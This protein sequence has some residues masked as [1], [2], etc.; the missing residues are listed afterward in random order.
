[1]YFK[2]DGGMDWSDIPEW[3][4]D[5]INEIERAT[6]KLIERAREEGASG[7]EVRGIVSEIHCSV[8][9]A[10]LASVINHRFPMPSEVVEEDEGNAG[11]VNAER[12]SGRVRVR[13]IRHAE[14]RVML[15]T[16]TFERL[17]EII[18]DIE[19]RVSDSGPSEHPGS[20]ATYGYPAYLERRGGLDALGDLE[21]K[22]REVQENYKPPKLTE[23]EK[24]VLL[25]LDL[26]YE[27]NMIDLGRWLRMSDER[28]AEIVASLRA[29]GL[30]KEGNITLTDEGI[31]VKRIIEGEG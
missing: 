13:A 16:I 28:M 8:N 12:G 27:R 19:E 25:R 18:D 11:V 17:F 3:L 30:V 10:M 9:T 26:W 1:M 6:G 2:E 21:R 24:T 15:K 23:Q 29:K 20:G 5:G 7:A 4:K 14:V 22:L 31:K